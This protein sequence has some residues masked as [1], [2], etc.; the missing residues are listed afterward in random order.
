MTYIPPTWTLPSG[1][2]PTAI[3][4]AQKVF[5]DRW[6]FGCPAYFYG[7]NSDILAINPI[8]VTS[9][10]I[11]IDCIVRVPVRGETLTQC[12]GFQDRNS[13]WIFVGDVVIDDGGRQAFV[14]RDR[15]GTF[16]LNFPNQSVGDL[17]EDSM[18]T[19]TGTIFDKEEKQ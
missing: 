18:Y 19:I 2:P 8:T 12:T 13:G 10:R 5:A 6:K 16:Y 11:S 17:L 3:F 14:D 7:D 1:Y 9:A 4:R 15:D